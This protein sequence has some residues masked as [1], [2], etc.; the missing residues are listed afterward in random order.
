MG[1]CYIGAVARM[2][3]QNTARRNGMNMST[4]ANAWMKLT[5]LAILT[6]SVGCTSAVSTSAICDGTTGLRTDHAAA[7]AQDGGALS[8]Q[9]G[10]QLIATID[11]GCGEG[12]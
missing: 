10:A 9:T 5:A 11:A 3:M 1:P 4:P 7:L 8:M 12:I 6:F 2:L